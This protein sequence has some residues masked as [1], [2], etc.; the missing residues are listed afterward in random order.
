MEI[1]WTWCVLAFAACT[2]PSGKGTDDTDPPTEETDPAGDPTVWNVVA[3]E[4]GGALLSVTGTSAEDVWAAGADDGQGPFVLHYDGET[5]TREATGTTGDL[6]WAWMP[7]GGARPWI[8][9]DHGRVLRP[10]GAGW[11]EM[12]VDAEI[13]LFGLWGPAEDDLWTV[14]G[15]VATASGAR[16]YHWD[17]SAWSRVELPDDADAETALYKVWGTGTDAV[18]ACGTGGLMLRWDGASWTRVP[19]GTDRTLLTLSG[20][21]DDAIWAV[22][23]IGNASIVHWDGATWADESPGFAR[24]M[25]GVNARDG[26]VA[27][28]GRAGEVW[29][30]GEDQTWTQD[31]RGRGTFLD[32]HAGWIDP[33]GGLWTVGGSIA[34]LPLVRGVLLYGGSAVVTAYDAP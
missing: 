5:W 14:G 3:E 10:T 30:R 17:G 9:G 24:E 22:G 32:L 12:V 31:A 26:H 8:S 19:S 13:T 6:W 21:G 18:W 34:T 25:N 4:L 1:R 27:A 16:M 15:N 20:T 7:P 23:G 28:V 29:L 2:D 33:D 11:E